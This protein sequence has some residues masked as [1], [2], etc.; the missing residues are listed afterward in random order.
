MKNTF[1]GSLVLLGTLFGCDPVHSLLHNG[2]DTT[3]YEVIF[4]EGSAGVY[5]KWREAQNT[6]GFYY[7]YTDRGRGPLL[8]EKIELNERNFITQHLVN[9]VNYLKDSV[10][11]KFESHEETASWINSGEE[12]HGTFTGN[13][14][15]FRY[16]GSPASYEI[17]SQLLLDAESGVVSLYPKGEAVLE[18]TYDITLDLDLNVKLLMIKGLDINPT[19][20]WLEDREMI[21]FISGNLHVVREDYTAMRPKMKSLQDSIENEYLHELAKN[22]THNINDLVIK[23]VDIFNTEGSL[24][25]N[26]DVFVNGATIVKMTPTGKTVVPMDALIIDGTGKTLMPGMFDMHTHNDKFRGALYLAGGITS[27][28]DLANNKQVKSLSDQFNKNQIM[29]PRIVAFCGI[30][31][32]PGPY[33]NQRNVVNSLAEGLNE[34][35]LY[36]DL[37]YQQIKLY[38]SIKPEWVEDLATK[39]HDLGMKVSGHIPAF[40]TASQAIHQGYDEIQHMNMLFLNFLSDTVDTRTPLRFTM[41]ANYGAKLDLSSREYLEF[42]ELLKTKQII[43]DPTVSIFEHMFISKKGEPSP[44][45]QAIVNRLPLINQRSYYKGGLPKSTENT[46]IYEQAHMR[47]LE[48]VFDLYQKGVA[49]VPGTDGLPG[50]LYHRELELYVKS[51]IPIA[52]VLKM[53]TIKSA[54]IAG[55]AGLY[56]SIEVGKKADLILVD[57]NPLNDI[58]DIRKIEWTSKEGKLFYVQELYQSMGIKH[59]K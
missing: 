42:T 29:G 56:G 13:E 17:I 33:A 49:I 1:I 20:L 19:Y 12:A 59:F 21:A 15:Y 26:Q 44:T 53:A 9:G 35:Q 41:V 40:M 7:T 36:K 58:S 57:G 43:V 3:R 23:N 48:V 55:V 39:A 24:N 30:I 52:E 54:E 5:K 46:N 32:G 50:F 2:S 16:D 22:L 11:E 27:V 25:T 8:K 51:G 31:D 10:D 47:M 14:L 6:Y 18:Q 28:R 4:R 34:I 37:G 38:S 45:Y